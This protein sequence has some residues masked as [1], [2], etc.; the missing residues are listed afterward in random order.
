MAWIYLAESEDSLTPWNPT[1][2]RLPIAKSIDMPK[3]YF[4]R[5]WSKSNCPSHLFGTM[6]EHYWLHFFPQLTLY[7]QGR[8]ARI[9]ALLAMETAWT[10][11]RAVFSGRSLASLAIWDPLTSSWKMCQQSLPGVVSESLKSLPQWGMSAG[12]VLLHLLPPKLEKVSG[13]SSW[14]RPR[15]QDAK[16]STLPP[17][18]KRLAEKK[19][20][21]GS[22]LS[23]PETLAISNY[24]GLL[25]P[26]FYEQLMMC[27][28][29]WTELNAV[30]IQWTGSKRVQR[31]KS[32]QVS[33]GLHSN[34]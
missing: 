28:I 4:C 11:S 34:D 32:S 17:S 12:G 5:E 23:I 2:S 1:S 16:N 8:L 10:E 3:G 14:P 20:A 31:L 13:G 18:V 25:N 9:S 7:R 22:G 6:C 30:G 19:R 24:T 33:G 26:R 27:P 29:G 15:A 21:K